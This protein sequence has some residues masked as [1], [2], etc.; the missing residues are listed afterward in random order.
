MVATGTGWG[1]IDEDASKSRLAAAVAPPT[2]ECLPPA[3]YSAQGPSTNALSGVTLTNAHRGREI[4]TPYGLPAAL[5]YPSAPL[6]RSSVY[7]STPR[8][9]PC[10]RPPATR[11]PSRGRRDHLLI[12]RRLMGRYSTNRADVGLTLS[13]S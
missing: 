6:I 4:L 10:R 2:T 9:R 8:G 13:S 3:V 12:R 7:M 1:Y 5:A 11:F